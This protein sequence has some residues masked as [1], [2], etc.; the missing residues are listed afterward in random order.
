MDN[1]WIGNYSYARARLNAEGVA[2]VDLDTDMRYTYGDL[3]CRAN[4]LANILR[5]QY[6]ISKGDRVAYISR[7]RVELIDG[8][9]ATGKLGVPSWCP[10]TPASPPRS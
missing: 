1:S 3:D 9:F 5:D 6:G 10:I 8:Y 2:V 7:S 4:T